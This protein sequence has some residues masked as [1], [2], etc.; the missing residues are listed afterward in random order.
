MNELSN[1]PLTSRLASGFWPWWVVGVVAVVV[2]VVVFIVF[3]TTSASDTQTADIGSQGTLADPVSIAGGSLQRATDGVRVRAEMPTP[4]AGSYGYPTSDMVP[5]G[6][7]E[8]PELLVGGPGEPETFTLWVFIFNHPDLCTDVCND[9]DLDPNAAA[10]GGAYQGDGRIAD[11]HRL[12]LEGGV[13]VGQEPMRGS[14][15][16][17][18]LDAEVHLAIAP[19]GKALEGA[20]LQRQLNGPIG[21]PAFWWPAAFPPP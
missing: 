13:R 4:T 10:K 14:P 15:L 16:E 9:D 8:H 21:N 19:H 6:A 18:P 2:V 1:R 7:P 12:I 5:L 11:G 20:L 17:S 3:S